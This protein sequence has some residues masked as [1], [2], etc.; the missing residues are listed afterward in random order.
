MPL[1]KK[2]IQLLN[3]FYF[4]IILWPLLF[5]FSHPQLF[6]GEFASIFGALSNHFTRLSNPSS[7]RSNLS[8][9]SSLLGLFLLLLLIVQPQ[10]P[11]FLH[12]LL[13]RLIV[14]FVIVIVI[15]RLDVK[16]AKGLG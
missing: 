8:A 9:P 15:Q 16:P 2:I 7:H 6:Y 12:L 10:I 11:T 14:V 1:C 5:V 4:C 13:F 3:N